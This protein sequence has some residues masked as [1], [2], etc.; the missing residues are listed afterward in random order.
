MTGLHEWRGEKLERLR[1]AYVDSHLK[2]WAIAQDFDTSPGQIARLR[3]IHGWPKRQ[4]TGVIRRYRA[5][6]QNCVDG[7]K[8]PD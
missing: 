7:P 3:K 6:T 4:G 1:V 2:L 8:P 5:Q